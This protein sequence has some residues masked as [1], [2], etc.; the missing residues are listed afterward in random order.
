MADIATFR[1]YLNATILITENAVRDAI[2][3]QGLTTF[4][5][6][7]NMTDQDIK[8]VCKNARSPGGMIQQGDNLLP[9]R[10]VTLGFMTEKRLRQ[11]RYYKYHLVCI[12]RTFERNEAT[13]ARLSAVWIRYEAEQ[14]DN[15]P[16]EPPKMAKSEEI[17]STLENID[18]YLTQK[19]GMYGSPLA[20]VTRET[21]ALPEAAD[22]QG[23]GVPSLEEE[24]IRR[25]MHTG[26]YYDQDNSEVWALL[27]AIM[28]DGP[29]WAWIQRFSRSHDGRA[30]YFAIRDHYLGSSFQSTIKT[31][32]T[33]TMT[34]TYY[35]GKSRHFTFD[36]YCIQLQK[37]FTDLEEYGEPQPESMKVR[38]FLENIQDARLISAVR[39]VDSN[40]D[41]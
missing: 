32:A 28:H 1:N 30:A 11:L 26:H 6:L 5:D 21:V 22:D 33:R 23:F 16:K 3:N 2:V 17:R 34:T 8:D 40:E 39:I 19:R 18:E 29:G 15:D 13:L 7:D 9:N 20:Y 14:E 10:G 31:N 25:T 37:A 38:I 24:L 12:Q 41:F 36:R 27:R 35:N 4:E